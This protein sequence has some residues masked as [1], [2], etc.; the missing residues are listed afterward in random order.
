MLYVASEW[1]DPNGRWH[2]GC[3]KQLAKGSNYWWIPARMLNIP[4]TEFIEMLVN[5][6][7]VDQ[8]Y[9][10]KRSNLLLYSWS[11]YA[12]AHRWLLFLNREARKRNFQI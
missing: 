3:T 5:E 1:E 6:Y 9:Y 11:N 10:F 12:D 7:K 8:L 2:V 4:L